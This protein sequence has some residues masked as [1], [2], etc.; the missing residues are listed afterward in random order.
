LLP[1]RVKRW[2]AEQARPIA[3]SLRMAAGRM[4]T[5][6]WLSAIVALAFV[7]R[8][9]L[10]AA[11]HTPKVL[12]DELVYTGLAKG[13]SLHGEPL[14]RGALDV[15]HSTF[16]PLLLAPAFHFAADGA[17]AL[18]ALKVINALM[19]AL[20]AVP[21]FALARRVVPRNWALLVAALSVAAPW[22]GYAAL[23]LTE[24]MFYPVF[25]AYAAVLVWTLERPS[26]PRQ[27]ATLGVLAAL[28]GV[29]AQ[30]LTVALG[31]LAAILLFG[32]LAGDLRAAIR[33]FW[34]TLSVYTAGLAIGVGAA[35]A[36]V[37]VPTGSYNVVFDSLTR[38]F[39]LLKWGG[40][41]AVLLGLALGAVAFAAFPV[42]LRQMLRRD[43]SSPVRATA[44]VALSL[45]LSLLGSVALL[46]ASP[47]GLDILHERNLFYVTPLLLTCLAY[48]LS[49]G[50]QRPF[51]LAVGSAAA[52]VALAALLPT[53]II[54]D[55]S[56]NVD[57]PSAFSAFYHVP[58]L[59]FRLSAILVATVGAAIFLFARRPLLPVLTI[60]L[61]FGAVTS[62]VDY[63][64]TLTGRQANA[65]SW[66]DRA[67]PHG[68]SA[69]IVY[70]GVPYGLQPC[71]AAATAEEQDLTTWTEFFNTRIRSVRYLYQP[72]A[73]DYLGSSPLTTAAGGLVLA[74]GKRFKTAY[75]VIDSRQ[76]IV[77]TRL[78]RF[79]LSSIH[80]QYQEGASL[81]LWRVTPPL[82][83]YSLPNPM[84]PRGDG[85]NC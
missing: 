35:A 43:A 52:T 57:V 17:A 30:G 9:V 39:G 76:S 77:G 72:N 3:R 74:N 80:S 8:A 53:H 54:V 82:R 70:L 63:T 1:Q 81:T 5:S 24:S 48:W 45:S 22:T 2:S 67:L 51:S 69:D 41:N 20:T 59:S 18:E 68:A 31:T 15:G 46:S 78:A 32:W 4:P 58:G 6:L 19:M 49:T 25:V 36:G 37:V 73:R 7:F 84:P 34:P 44:V 38:V 79:D 50:Q 66:V 28:V 21:A 23:A 29:R 47:Y 10:G 11:N 12:G 65:L 85:Q 42:A 26:L 16:Y 62:Q 75:L 13:W 61:A 33:R 56:N 71:A 14:L 55:R 83:L 64:D 60:V 27:L 40:W